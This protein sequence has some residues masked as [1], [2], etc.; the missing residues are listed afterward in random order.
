MIWISQVKE[1]F[2]KSIYKRTDHRLGKRQRN[3]FTRR[4]VDKKSQTDVSSAMGV[5]S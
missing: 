1:E 3:F 5:V 4:L 2:I